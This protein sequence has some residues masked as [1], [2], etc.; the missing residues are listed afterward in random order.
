MKRHLLFRASWHAVNVLLIVSLGAVLYSAGWEF[1]TRSYLK[2]FSD[3]VVSSSDSPEQKV[4]AI[5][6]WMQHGPAR[7]STTNPDLLDP[8]NPENTLNYQQLLEVCG[9]A[10]NA[11][12]NLARSSGLRA[13]RLL[14]LDDKRYAKH[15]VAEVLL[16]ARWV[17]VDPTY[18]T[19]FQVPTGRLATR[20]D[21][22]NPEI[23][24]AAT[25]AI[26]NYP[27]SYTYESTVHVRLSAF[28][29]VGPYLRRTLNFIWPAWEE[30][31]NWTL[32]LERA[33]FA[34]LTISIFL[35][36]FALAARLVLGW[37]CSRRLGIVRVRLRDQ[38]IRAGTALFSNSE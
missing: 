3:A 19:M 29:T 12:V 23:F 26:P 20:T 22:Q 31:I 24:R 16:G 10:T 28:P 4:E 34:M 36:C 38:L 14:L 2:G 33:S 1:S 11:F 18:R 13:R 6:A 21:L 7:R 37:Y 27:S 8:R 35:L 9:T 25:A 17:I 30:S 15:V 5:L 32:L